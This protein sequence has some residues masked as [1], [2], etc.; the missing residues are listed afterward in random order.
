MNTKAS[1]AD[2][3]WVTAPASTARMW[4]VVVGLGVLTVAAVCAGLL[5]GEGD[6]ANPR[7][8]DVLLELRGYR[9][10]SA[11]LVGAA[12]ATGGVLVQGLFRNPL[13][14]PSI[15]GATAGA[16]FG[17]KAAL[18]A[19]ELLLAGSAPAFVAPGCIALRSLRRRRAVAFRGRS[20]PGA[21]SRATRGCPGARA[22]PPPDRPAPT[23]TT[24]APARGRRPRCASTPARTS[25]RA[26]L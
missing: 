1:H 21:G 22:A 9:L 11:F 17:G 16:A 10:A 19:F 13:A 18:V 7:L 8:R 20:R 4:R 26:S 2:H 23:A 24:A 5:V 12:M 15:V 25:P 14:S 3:D 6:L